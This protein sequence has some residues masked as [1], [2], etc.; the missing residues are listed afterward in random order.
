SP[1]V[2]R[3]QDDA[4]PNDNTTTSN[5]QVETTA[6]SNPQDETMKDVD[7]DNT[8]AEPSSPQTLEIS[9]ELSHKPNHDTPIDE[10]FTMI[11]S[12]EQDQTWVRVERKTPNL[13]YEFRIPLDKIKGDSTPGKLQ[14][15]RTEMKKLVDMIDGPTIRESHG[16]DYVH[17]IVRYEANYTLLKTSPYIVAQETDD[18]E[19]IAQ[20]WEHITNEMKCAANA[21]SIHLAHI[22]IRIQEDQVRG[23][24]SA[25]GSIESS[26]MT[27][28]RQGRYEYAIVTFTNTQAVEKVRTNHGTMIMIGNSM[29]RIGQLGTDRVIWSGEVMH[30][31]RPLSRGCTDT[32]LEFLVREY[33]A[34]YAH[35]PSRNMEKVRHR[36]AHSIKGCCFHCGSSDRR[37]RSCPT[38]YVELTQR[39]MKASAAS[40]FRSPPSLPRVPASMKHTTP[41]APTFAQ[42][43]VGVDNAQTSAA[44]TAN[45]TTINPTTINPTAIKPTIPRHLTAGSLTDIAFRNNMDPRWKALEKEV[46]DIHQETQRQLQEIQSSLE[47]LTDTVHGMKS[48]LNGLN[49]TLGSRVLDITEAIEILSQSVNMIQQSSKEN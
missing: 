46:D 47:G 14:K 28:N 35:I 21:R 13:G 27:I 12:H 36:Y 37:S 29:V 49:T 6:T 30:V 26:R 44:T 22:P 11:E 2:T 39:A 16:V 43:V 17:I 42:I 23:A 9:Q 24:L 20:P 25:F 33:G 38:H 31:L 1:L 8:I 7:E 40:G 18:E 10:T 32:D 4:K 15:L 34:T 5:P 41:Y 48:L 45:P 3:L 19:A